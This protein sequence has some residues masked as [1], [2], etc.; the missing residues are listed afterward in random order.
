MG[1]PVHQKSKELFQQVLKDLKVPKTEENIIE[2]FTVFG[3]DLFHAGSTALRTGTIIGIPVNFG[4]ETD[5]DVNRKIKV[6][7]CLN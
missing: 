4:Y 1:Q 6:K 7:I 5:R 2:I 3:F